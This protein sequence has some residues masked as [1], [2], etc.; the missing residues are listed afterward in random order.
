MKIV[1]IAAF[2]FL[3]STLLQA[4][5]AGTHIT[6]SQIKGKYPQ[7]FARNFSRPLFVDTSFSTKPRGDT[8]QHNAYGDLRTDIPQYNQK[9]P[10]WLCAT[11]VFLNNALTVGFDR[12]VLDA[13][14]ARI[15]PRTWR[16]NIQ[17]G[18][19]WDVDRFGMNYFAHPYSGSGYFNA[20][21]SNGYDFYESVPFAF[22]GSLMYEY[23]GE[24][25]L[26]SYNDLI[27][28]T[29][30]G[31]FLGEISYRLSS[32]FLDDQASGPERFFREF[33]AGVIDPQRA[34]SRLLRGRLW[35]ET[36]EEIYQKEPL[37]MT[38]TAGAH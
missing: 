6:S 23:F 7:L 21:R 1:Y 32:D 35:R 8:M 15:G 13:D 26:P 30:T 9:S 11:R 29:I 4:Q 16:H 38:F 31:T 19:E 10:I 2:S 28:T 3:F 25:T 34:F 27:N 14:F 24:N 37:N 18:W 12:Y 17:T 33:F 20:A 22:G 36:S 5:D